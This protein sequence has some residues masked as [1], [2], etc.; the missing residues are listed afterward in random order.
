MKNAHF[1]LG[2][3]SWVTPIL[4]RFSVGTSS[5]DDGSDAPRGERTPLQ[6][7]FCLFSTGY[8]IRLEYTTT[9]R[10]SVRAPT[11]AFQLIQYGA[12]Q[13]RKLWRLDFLKLLSNYF[14]EKNP[15]LSSGTQPKEFQSSHCT[16]PKIELVMLDVNLRFV[17]CYNIYF[18]IAPWKIS[19]YS[20]SISN[21]VHT[22]SLDN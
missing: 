4:R 20:R 19:F 17:G 21:Y 6:R 18:F 16:C 10:S 8:F 2:F 14:R 5:G 3:S 9:F 15:I 12:L 11:L 13:Q 7:E 22:A 1:T